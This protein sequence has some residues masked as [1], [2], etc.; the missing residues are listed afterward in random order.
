MLSF[1]ALNTTTGL[2]DAGDKA[3]YAITQSLPEL[4]GAMIGVLFSILGVV[5]L[6]LIIYG[7]FTW[8]TSAGNSKSVENAKN[9]MIRATVGLVITLSAFAISS[10]IINALQQSQSATSDSSYSGSLSP[11]STPGCIPPNC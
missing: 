4:V 2:G 1:L 6:V 7:G 10:F 8:M 3:G 11:T 9:I 5:F